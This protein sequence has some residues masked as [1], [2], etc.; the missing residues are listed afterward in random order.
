MDKQIKVTT[1]STFSIRSFNTYLGYIP[2]MLATFNW[3][4]TPKLTIT[5]WKENSGLALA[6]KKLPNSTYLVTIAG[7]RYYEVYTNIE[8]L[9][10]AV[11]TF[12]ETNFLPKENLKGIVK[13]Q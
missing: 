12:I 4:L 10:F 5:D 6:I 11:V 7:D 8:E 3:S 9:T 2:S 1:H 13:W